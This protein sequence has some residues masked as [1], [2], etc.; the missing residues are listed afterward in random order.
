MLLGVEELLLGLALLEVQ[1]RL[2]D[3]LEELPYGLVGKGP[4][5]F[6]GEVTEHLLLPLGVIVG[7]AQLRLDA[8]DLLDQAAPLG[9]E[10][11]ELPVDPVH[12]LAQ[13]EDALVHGLF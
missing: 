11:E 5:V 7:K 3:L 6:P 2:K 9:K 4:R 10:P 12:L 13:G 8:A 1:A